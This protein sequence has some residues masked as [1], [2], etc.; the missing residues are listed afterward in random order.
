MI[1]ADLGNWKGKSNVSKIQIWVQQD[2]TEKWQNGSFTIQNVC[3]SS[4][5]STTSAPSLTI[6]ESGYTGVTQDAF[7]AY[8][9]VSGTK[10]V[11]RVEYSAWNI[12]FSTEKQL[13][14]REAFLVDILSAVSQFLSWMENRCIW[15]SNCG[16]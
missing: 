15:C 10:P 13:Q 9:K 16:I 7:T 12:A 2:G 3:Q 5:I 4:S 6:T 11:A 8:C 1:Y 14:S